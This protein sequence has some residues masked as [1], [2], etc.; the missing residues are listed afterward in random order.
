[1]PASVTPRNAGHVKSTT[2]SSSVWLID[3]L[4]DFWLMV[5]SLSRVWSPKYISLALGTSGCT[6]MDFALK[7]CALMSL[8]TK[9]TFIHGNYALLTL[10]LVG[11]LWWASLSWFSFSWVVTDN[12][13]RRM[14]HSRNSIYNYAHHSSKLWKIVGSGKFSHIGCTLIKIS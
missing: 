9:C 5:N 6:L 7:L 12:I 10:A 13:E 2:E 8:F 3:W 1:M 14:L 11:A 4:I